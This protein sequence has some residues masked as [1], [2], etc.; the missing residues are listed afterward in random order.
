MKCIHC[1]EPI[2]ELYNEKPIHW[3]CFSE[4][5]R[6]QMIIR[7]YMIHEEMKWHITSK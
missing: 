6:Q 4:I 1:K 3:Y 5:M 2:K 7:N